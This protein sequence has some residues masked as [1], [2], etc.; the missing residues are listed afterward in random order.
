MVTVFA[1]VDAYFLLYLFKQSTSEQQLAE[2][3]FLYSGV[4]GSLT[5]YAEEGFKVS[6]YRV[7]YICIQG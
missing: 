5:T 4:V 7:T 3:Y 2:V 1:I 6:I